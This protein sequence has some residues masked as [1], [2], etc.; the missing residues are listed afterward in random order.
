M[1]LM[2]DRS[3]L[4]DICIGNHGKSVNGLR[5]YRKLERRERRA[6]LDA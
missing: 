4:V 2:V 5:R 6:Y 1:V 3:P